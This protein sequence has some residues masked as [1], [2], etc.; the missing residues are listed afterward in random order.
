MFDLNSP[1][2]AIEEALL[3]TAIF[4]FLLHW[5]YKSLRRLKW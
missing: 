2:A 5:V 4:I 3:R 1:L